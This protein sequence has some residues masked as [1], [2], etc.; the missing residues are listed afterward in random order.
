MDANPLLLRSRC[1]L[2][3]VMFPVAG[4]KSPNA[5]VEECNNLQYLYI[6]AYIMCSFYFASVH[7]TDLQNIIIFIWRLTTAEEANDEVSQENS[8]E[9]VCVQDYC[10]E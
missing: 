2:N 6:F 1:V 3:V 5:T 7:P 4:L 10:K 9:V 8:R